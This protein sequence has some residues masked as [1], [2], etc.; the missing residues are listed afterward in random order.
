M[1]H[2][3]FEPIIYRQEDP[4][5]PERS[6]WVRISSWEGS[7]TVA[8]FREQPDAE[9]SMCKSITSFDFDA[10]YN[11]QS[12]LISWDEQSDPDND[13]GHEVILVSSIDNWK[14]RSQNDENLT[15]TQG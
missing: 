2:D 8:T 5:F 1:L 9:T 4:N 3:K 10:C 14:P 11:D 7:V 15:C 12:K 6:V 13:D